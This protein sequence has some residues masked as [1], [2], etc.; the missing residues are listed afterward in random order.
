MTTNPK[1]PYAV[2]P[3]V[4]ALL[5]WLDADPA[6][7]KR[8]W[9][10]PQVASEYA[11][12]ISTAAALLGSLASHGFLA[13]STDD[14]AAL[15]RTD[16]ALP[17][18]SDHTP[19]LPPF[20]LRVAHTLDALQAE[21]DAKTEPNAEEAWPTALEIVRYSQAHG[22]DLERS[23]VG[24][25]LETLALYG[26][27]SRAQGS[28]CALWRRTAKPLPSP[29]LRA[30]RVVETL[31]RVLG[32]Q[33]PQTLKRAAAAAEQHH[34]HLWDKITTARELL[35]L[36]E[37]E[38]APVKTSDRQRG[39]WVVVCL[40]HQE[41]QGRELLKTLRAEAV[42]ATFGA[43]QYKPLPRTPCPDTPTTQE[44][45]TPQ[46]NTSALKPV[47]SSP[48]RSLSPTPARLGSTTPA[49][50]KTSPTPTSPSTPKTSPPA[51]RSPAPPHSPTE[52]SPTTP[53]SR[54]ARAFLSP[55]MSP[56]ERIERIRAAFVRALPRLRRDGSV[57][58]LYFSSGQLFHRSRDDERGHR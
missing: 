54:E 28:R 8:S 9:T 25:A 58:E 51:P 33:G 42:A 21:L 6:R 19:S 34:R 57:S 49:P 44:H 35:V 52:P 40:P 20:A 43:T 30:D 10:P 18:F 2:R 11:C 48:P 14:P 13:A 24:A 27:V 17:N 7:A 29:K 37:K 45:S 36:R 53:T 47:T 55:D 1:V 38:A 46:P 15:A 56:T 5:R 41:A 50:T 31:V 39:R 4:L 23:H 22:R 16:K 26:F 32:E 3:N 12:A